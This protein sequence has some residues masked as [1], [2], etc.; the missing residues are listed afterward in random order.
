MAK[1]GFFA[2]LLLLSLVALSLA[3]DSRLIKAVHQSHRAA[4]VFLLIQGGV[5]TFN[6]TAARDACS[7]LN[8]TMATI[9]QME[10]ALQQGL[11]TCKF[12][13]IAERVAVVPRL[14]TDEKCGRG[15]TGVVRWAAST[16]TKFGV[17]CFNA[18]DLE[19]TKAP[20][21]SQQSFTSPTIQT[22]VTPTSTPASPVPSLTSKPPPSG[23]L[24]TTKTSELTASTSSLQV[25]T[26]LTRIS[27]STFNKLFSSHIPT[28]PSHLITTETKDIHLAS[29]TP[30]H[31]SDSSFTSESPTQPTMVHEKPSLGDVPT[32]LIILG[33]I[34]LLLTAA[35]VVWYYK[36]NIFT[37][38]SEPQQKD[39]IET[40][41]WKH[42]HS[43]MD[44]H[45]LHEG[46]AE[47]EELARTYSSD[48][49]LCVNP[50]L[51]TNSLE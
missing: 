19:E 45:S 50:D 32:A 29:S 21:P 37:F 13:W 47:D 11:E 34:V 26:S 41:M 39:D 28:P 25:Q 35:G 20:A 3:S 16:D 51:K 2:D 31:A 30:A 14:T 8:V 24:R 12:G 10:K 48:I 38:W 15:K 6:F 7:F 27:A 36:L 22:A 40:Q 33:I 23:E 43:E 42:N 44:L 18:S 49:T 46:E 4:G 5:Y 17:F 1:I 9:T